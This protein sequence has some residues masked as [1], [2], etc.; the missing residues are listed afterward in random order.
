MK[1]YFEYNWARFRFRCE[2]KRSLIAECIIFWQ[3]N[4]KTVIK[5]CELWAI[6]KFVYLEST[7]ASGV[8]AEQELSNLYARRPICDVISE[9]LDLGDGGCL[10]SSPPSGL[11][12]ETWR[13][14]STTLRHFL[15][16]NFLAF[17][18]GRS[19]EINDHVWLSK[20]LYSLP[21]P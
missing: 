14:I 12:F 9:L 5:I 19:L 10:P 2:I 11:H 13:W 20:P 4:D 7:P 16:T 17:L 6:F 3:M 8:T 1:A 15:V 21:L 18:H